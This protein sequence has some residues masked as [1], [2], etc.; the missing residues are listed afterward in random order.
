MVITY[1]HHA[2]ESETEGLPYIHCVG[3]HS[4]FLARPC[5]KNQKLQ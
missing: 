4:E 2:L 3:L 1:E 5:F